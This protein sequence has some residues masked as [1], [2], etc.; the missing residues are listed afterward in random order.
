[1]FD[2]T[3]VL[4]VSE[5][6]T[7]DISFL[8]GEIHNILFFVAPLDSS[9]EAVLGLNWLV[10]Y[11]LLVDWT[12]CQLTFHTTTSSTVP[13]PVKST[14]ALPHPIAAYAALLSDLSPDIRLINATIFYQATQL[15][16]SRT[17]F[18]SYDSLHLRH[19]N[20]SDEVIDLSS[21][22]DAY[23]DFSNIFSKRRADSLPEHRPYDL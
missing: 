5:K 17:F 21:V 15:E 8:S 3:S 18:I 4:Y 14:S 7:L 16:G 10:K 11:N 20:L 1:M 22:P 13:F 2:G 9:C 19:A 6:I 12:I 23:H